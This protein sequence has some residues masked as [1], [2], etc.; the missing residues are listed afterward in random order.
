M[1][2]RLLL[3]RLRTPG[4]DGWS[5]ESVMREAA[6]EIE[7]LRDNLAATR[8]ELDDWH[9]EF[10]SCKE[11]VEAHKSFADRLA[12]PDE[13]SSA[14]SAAGNLPTEG[15]PPSC[16]PSEPATGGAGLTF[17]SGGNS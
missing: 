16:E 14:L 1:T 9:T 13:P 5:P 2:N 17:K 15:L 3:Q 6:D 8:A 10:C 4:L 11:G 7:R 12:I